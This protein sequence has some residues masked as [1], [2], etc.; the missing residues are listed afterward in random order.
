VLYI[1][2]DR[3]DEDVFRSSL[4]DVAVRVGRTARSAAEWYV[5]RQASIDELLRALLAA[6]TRRDG[7][8]DR[9]ESLVRAVGA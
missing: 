4:I 2:D 7:L 5:P 6:C 3:T 8:G 1:G 9:S